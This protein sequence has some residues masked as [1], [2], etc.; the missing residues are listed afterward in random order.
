MSEPRRQASHDVPSLIVPL[1]KLGYI[2]PEGMKAPET[3]GQFTT[4]VVVVWEPD[5]DGVLQ[6]TS[7]EIV[8]RNYDTNAEAGPGIFVKIEEM[9]GEWQ[10]YYF[11]C[12]D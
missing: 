11:G 9:F 2:G 6:N 10:P 3:K 7:D 12:E 4:F 8:A 5:D 1:R